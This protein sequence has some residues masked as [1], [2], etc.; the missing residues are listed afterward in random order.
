[1]KTKYQPRPLREFRERKTA[2]EIQAEIDLLRA[3]YAQ[4]GSQNHRR[5]TPDDWIGYGLLTIA[6]AVPAI[7]AAAILLL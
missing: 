6:L 3:I 5:I 7:A 4:Q 2:A 1:M